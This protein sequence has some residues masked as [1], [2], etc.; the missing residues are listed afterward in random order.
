MDPSRLFGNSVGALA[1]PWLT[2]R[3]TAALVL[4]GV[5][6]L[7]FRVFRERC[8][9]WW[10]AGWLA[11]GAFLWAAGS[12][13]HAASKPM[14]AFAQADF[15]LALGLFATAAL[16]SA[17]ARRSLTIIAALMWVVLVCAAMRALYFPDA[18]SIALGLE[19][20]CRL[21]A[22]AAAV[23]LARF[24]LGRIGVGPFLFGAGSL[25]LNLRWLPY[26]AH[27]PNEGY[28]LAEVLFGMS[29]LLVVL[30]DDVSLEKLGSKAVYAA[31]GGYRK[32]VDIIPC[33]ASV[34]EKRA[35]PVVVADGND[36]GAPSWRSRSC[37]F[38]QPI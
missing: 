4:V 21:L 12:N 29:I 16:I 27:V 25:I 24:R 11:Y 19:I 33:R 23:H 28:L 18:K 17:Q 8:L 35:T 6:L 26:T 15:V 3:E 38:R 34:L 7:L 14:V 1:A 13:A 36:T 32:P 5:S 30:D 9:L 20:A 31:R 2:A 37:K 10:G 22:F